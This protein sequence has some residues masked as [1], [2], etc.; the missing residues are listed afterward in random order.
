VVR[1]GVMCNFPFAQQLR[2]KS[3]IAFYSPSAIR[4]NFSAARI[5]ETGAGNSTISFFILQSDPGG[6]HLSSNRAFSTE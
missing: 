4:E 3:I 6:F 1:G 2:L 5:L